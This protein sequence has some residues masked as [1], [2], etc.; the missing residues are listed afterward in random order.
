MVFWIFVTEFLRYFWK[1]ECSVFH[2]LLMIGEVL[3]FISSKKSIWLANNAMSI[4]WSS[5]FKHNCLLFSFFCSYTC[6]LCN[7]RQLYIFELKEKIKR[8]IRTSFWSFHFLSYSDHTQMFI[9]ISIHLITWFLVYL[10]IVDN[11]NICERKKWLKGT[12]KQIL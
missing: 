2:F 12:L 7:C 11:F 5:S 3:S 8:C 9:A 10:V 4:S 6:K 1:T